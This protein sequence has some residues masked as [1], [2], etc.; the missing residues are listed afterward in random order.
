MANLTDLNLAD[1]EIHLYIP[2]TVEA[3][4]PLTRIVQE[5]LTGFPAP[6]KSFGTPASALFP[7]QPSIPQSLLSSKRT[8][9]SNR[10]ETS[11]S[12]LLSRS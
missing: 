9:G 10:T 2:G 1:V 12:S 5:S 11:D 7:F 3:V 6:P 4:H 8:G